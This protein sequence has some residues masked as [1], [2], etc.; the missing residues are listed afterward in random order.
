MIQFILFDY[1]VSDHWSNYDEKVRHIG[2]VRKAG[3]KI[4]ELDGK[5]R[6]KPER[7]VRLAVEFHEDQ[8]DEAILFKLRFM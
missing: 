7:G 4:V 8:E 2:V 5:N 1:D 3:Y 6:G